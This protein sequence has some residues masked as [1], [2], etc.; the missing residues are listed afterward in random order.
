[1]VG[2]SLVPDDSAD[3]LTITLAHPAAYFLAILAQPYA[4]VIER[5]VVNG[6]GTDGAWLANLSSGP[7][8]EGGSGIFYLASRDATGNIVLKPNPHWWGASA[9]KK[10]NFTE[11]DVHARTAIPDYAAFLASPYD[12]VDVSPPGPFDMAQSYPAYH[13]VPELLI[14]SVV[15][16]WKVPPFDNADARQA[17]CLAIN[18]DTVMQGVAQ[19]VPAGSSFIPYLPTWHLVPRGMPGYDAS[20]TGIDG[21][22]ATSGDLAKAE[23][24]WQAYLATLHG[25]APPP[26]VFSY[27]GVTSAQTITAQTVASQ[28]SNAFPGL[29]ASAA[30][31]SISGP[32]NAVPSIPQVV[33]LLW[34]A[35]FPDPQDFLSNLYATNGAYNIAG[36][37][38]PSADTLLAQADATSDP[39]QQ[40]VRMKLYNQAEQELVQQVATCPLFQYQSA[41]L[42][43]TDIYGM[44]Q[45][46]MG[47]I[48]DDDWVT[49]YRTV[50]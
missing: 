27:N 10:S 46:G 44:R 32:I 15:F 4:S 42:L 34:L 49:G 31:V 3:T 14:T 45:N 41:Y 1:M 19:S 40:A 12:Y 18:R 6:L 35:D 28:W 33:R 8:G 22:T 47:I 7:T 50:A 23:A 21:V 39:S 37:S 16:N 20:L 24:H 36:A 13:V 26:I 30:Q 2:D 17:L 43:R 25:K 48:A 11:I 38:V 9:G 29:K 5:Q